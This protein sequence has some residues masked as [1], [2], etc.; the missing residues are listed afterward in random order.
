MSKRKT[1]GRLLTCN[2]YRDHR[3][4]A[5]IEDVSAED[6]DRPLTTL[7]VADGWIQLRPYHFASQ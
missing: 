1:G 6:E 5:F 4:R 7:F 3:P 2:R